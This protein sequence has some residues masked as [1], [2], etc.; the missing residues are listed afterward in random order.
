M[1]FVQRDSARVRLTVVSFLVWFA[2][3]GFVLFGSGL[4]WALSWQATLRCERATDSCVVRSA[5]PGLVTD[6]HRMALSALG[7]AK[8]VQRGPLFQ[9]RL[10]FGQPD[11]TVA[12]IDLSLLSNT[13]GGDPQTEEHLEQFLAGSTLQVLELTT[14]TAADWPWAKWIGGLPFVLLGLLIGLASVSASIIVV[15]LDQRVLRQTAFGAT[16]R[17]TSEVSLADVRR[18]ELEE[19]LAQGSGLRRGRHRS[20]AVLGLQDGSV[21]GLD[22]GDTTAHG[23]AR[24]L[25]A[26]LRP[27]IDG[28]AG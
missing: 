16:W 24:R 25:V 1:V 10:A 26:L 27:I 14:D 12:W 28:T 21:V 13:L 22:G 5:F 4:I 17:M 6:E 19:W 2:F 11:G 15:D 18:V 3:A 9:R 8:T 20:R 23:D 7:R